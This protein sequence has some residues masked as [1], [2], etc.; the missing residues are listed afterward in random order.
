MLRSALLE[1]EDCMLRS[2]LLEEGQDCMLRSALQAKWHK[3]STTPVLGNSCSHEEPP[4]QVLNKRQNRSSS[5]CT[6]KL[7]PWDSIVG[8]VLVPKIGPSSNFSFYKLEPELTIVTGPTGY[9]PN[10]GQQ[11][12]Y[13][14]CGYLKFLISRLNNHSLNYYI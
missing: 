14:F 7:K 10:I 12:D 2:A 5:S 11:D 3:K 9:P 4:V 6:Q 1:G 13:G 8:L